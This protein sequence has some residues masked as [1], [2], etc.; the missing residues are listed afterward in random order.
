METTGLALT[1]IL[2]EAEAVQPL[3]LVTVT[4]YSADGTGG[5]RERL[6]EL[7]PPVFELQ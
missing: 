3:I 2:L 6:G 5:Y 4:T 7:A 1:V